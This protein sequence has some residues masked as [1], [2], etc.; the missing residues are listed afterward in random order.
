MALKEIP[1]ASDHIGL[2]QRHSIFLQFQAAETTA[3][4]V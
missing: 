1:Y 2:P 3:R 4:A